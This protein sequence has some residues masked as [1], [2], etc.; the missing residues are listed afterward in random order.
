ME[1]GYG[2]QGETNTPAN[3]GQADSGANNKTGGNQRS[4]S[5]QQLLEDVQFN[6]TDMK[7]AALSVVS[8]QSLPAQYHH[9]LNGQYMQ[10]APYAQGQGQYPPPR[11]KGPPS[12]H[13]QH[14]PYGMHEASSAGGMMHG[15]YDPS[16]R[17]DMQYQQQQQQHQYQP[18]SYRDYGGGGLGYARGFMPM[19]SR[20]DVGMGARGGRGVGRGGGG[21]GGGRQFNRK[22]QVQDRLSENKDRTIYVSEIDH[23]VT[24]EDLAVLFSK[25]GDVVDC[26]LCGDAH[27]RMRFAFIEFSPETGEAA[28][29]KALSFNNYPLGSYPIRVLKSRTAIVPVKRD[30]MP[31]TDDD[32]ERCQRTIYVSK[33]RS[34]LSEQ[35]VINF[36]ETMCTGEGDLGKVNKIRLLA[37]DNHNTA[38]AFVEFV[39]PETASVALANCQGA[40][41][42][43][44]PLRVSPSKTPVRSAEEDKLAKEA[45]LQYQQQQQQQQSAASM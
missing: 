18:P 43:C 21:R 16:Y 42:G 20:F 10:E 7:P 44:L 5:D 32:I 35:D 22:T 36:F 12:Q 14:R 19:G 24:E 25:C 13:Q 2:S 26:R 8:H 27:S 3:G 1:Q 15:M 41:M 17:S 40:L 11:W 31:Q 38:I 45:E 33:F 4:N 6:F 39:T 29:S 28:V 34:R 37:D 30:K 23:N 9:S